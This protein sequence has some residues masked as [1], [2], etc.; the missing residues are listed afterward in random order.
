MTCEMNHRVTETVHRVNG[1][2]LLCEETGGG[3]AVGR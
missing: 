1:E 3:R 2:R